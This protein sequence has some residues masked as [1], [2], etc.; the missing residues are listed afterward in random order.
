MIETLQKNADLIVLIL[1]VISGVL[2][3]FFKFFDFR[4]KSQKLLFIKD[5][6]ESVVNKLSSE[7]EIERVS[8]AIL[9]RRF[10]DKKSE[11]GIGKTPYKTETINIIA[12]ILRSSPIGLFQKVLS[13]SLAYAEDLNDV[14]LQRANLQNAY[15]GNKSIR[16]VDFSRADFFQANLS[17]ASLNGV[18]A[19]GAVF[20]NAILAGTV[21]TNAD[22][23]NANFQGSDLLKAKFKNADLEN[24]NFQGAINIPKEVLMYLDE[25]SFY[26]RNNKNAN[27]RNVTKKNNQIFIS[28]PGI[29]NFEQQNIVDF[30]IKRLED[31]GFSIIRVSPENYTDTGQLSEVKRLISSCSGVVSFGFND[32]LIKEGI[33]RP[34]TNSSNNI[35]NKWLSTPWIQIEIAMSSMLGIPILMIKND[36][37]EGVFDPLINETY[38]HSLNV[39]KHVQLDK[40]ENIYKC[41]KDN[42]D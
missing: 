11:F 40:F 22:L 35:K 36:V 23:K 16:K 41:W 28:S 33:Q 32:I 13:D 42:I 30:T 34:E 26:S 21:F 4:S 17:K 3:A 8:A 19:N 18:I 38:L 2:I 31:D 5:S 20:Y 24:A 14:D 6:F 9:L 27:P 29:L 39:I 15:L 12:S 25:N 7:S 37:N 10:F 1:A